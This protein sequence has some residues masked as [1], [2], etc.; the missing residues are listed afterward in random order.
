[1]ATLPIV[2]Y[3]R[4]GAFLVSE[5]NDYRSRDE[6]TIASGQGKLPPGTVLALN[7]ATGKY[8]AWISGD[9]TYGTA[10]ALLFQAVDATSADVKA[11]GITRDA[12][13]KKFLVA[14]A[15]A[16]NAAQKLAAYGQLQ[17]KGI[18]VR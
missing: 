16:P 3:Q 5:A 2:S 18:V 10:S 6:I 17:S 13:A 7:A 8:G 11:T 9:A 15:G 14:F 1:M 4:T 12:E